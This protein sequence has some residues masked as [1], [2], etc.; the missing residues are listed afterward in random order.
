MHRLLAQVRHGGEHRHR[1]LEL[2]RGEEDARVQQ[3]RAAPGVEVGLAVRSVHQTLQRAE[4]V[5][6]AVTACRRVAARGRGR[7]QAGSEE[8]VRRGEL[9]PQPVLDRPLPLGRNLT[10]RDRRVGRRDGRVDEPRVRLHLRRAAPVL[11]LGGEDEP[12]HAAAGH[13]GAGRRRAVR[14]GRGE[15]RREPRRNGALGRRRGGHARR[16][17]VIGAAQAEVEQRPEGRVVAAGEGDALRRWLRRRGVE[18]A[19]EAQC[20]GGL[21]LDPW[22]TATARRAGRCRDAGSKL[23]AR[24]LSKVAEGA[25]QQREAEGGVGAAIGALVGGQRPR[26]AAGVKEGAGRLRHLCEQTPARD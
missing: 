24:L 10:S 23:V 3:R 21:K 8:G 14:R 7:R 13:T 17:G 22:L 11:F 12:R 25:A 4:R 1:P 2:L 18:A 20:G 9:V 16:G 15:K 26:A 19:L 6:R 5:L